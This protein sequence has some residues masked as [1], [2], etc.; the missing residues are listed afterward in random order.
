MHIMC[1]IVFKNSEWNTDSVN[2]EFW[3]Q[4]ELPETVEIYKFA[5][6]GK[7]SGTDC[8]YKWKLEGSNNVYVNKWETLY[9]VENE[10]VN[11]VMKYYY[12]RRNVGYSTY[13]IFVHEAEGINPGLSYWQLFKL[14]SVVNS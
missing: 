8:I 4:I 3:I 9:N 5:L 1:L 14:D 7:S 2:K 12:V 11:N 13:R 10:P 6:R